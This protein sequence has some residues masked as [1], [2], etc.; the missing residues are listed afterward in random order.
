ML[1]DTWSPSN[2]IALVAI[3]VGAA[4]AFGAQWVQWRIREEDRRDHHRREAA[5]ALGPVY[6][7]INEV[8]SAMESDAEGWDPDPFHRY[9]ALLDDWR[10]LKPAIMAMGVSYPQARVRDLATSLANNIDQ[11][12]CLA[13]AAAAT[14]TDTA[15]DSPLD[16]PVTAEGAAALAH[17]GYERLIAARAQLQ[18]L[19]AVIRGDAQ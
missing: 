17:G 2:T 3:V 14:Q 1:A 11:A 7:V 9:Q 18:Q 12:L 19:A 5:L 4:G 10:V 16:G 6:S 13:S 15:E 8:D